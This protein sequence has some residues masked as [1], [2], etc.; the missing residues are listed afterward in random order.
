LTNNNYSYNIS[1]KN[2]LI[3]RIKYFT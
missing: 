1:Y 2:S 3:E